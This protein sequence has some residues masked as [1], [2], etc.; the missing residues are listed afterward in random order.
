MA[1]NNEQ[2]KA[3]HDT[4]KVNETKKKTLRTNREALR[5]RI[6]KYFKD[7]HSDYI[8]PKFCWQGSFA[9]NTI[10]NPIKDEGGLGVYDLDDGIYFISDTEDD[11]KELQWY[12]DEV[13]KA[14]EGHTDKGQKDNAPCVTVLYADRHHVDLPI[15]F[16]I[17]GETPQLAHQESFWLE[18][19]PKGLREW[20]NEECNDKSNLKA[21]VRYLK[22]WRD[23][24]DSESDNDDPKMPTG[25]ILT[26]L[27]EEYYVE[28]NADKRED[29]QLKDILIKMYDA[30]SADDGFHCWRPVTPFDDLFDDYKE[31]RKKHFLKELK[32][33]KE[34][35]ERAINL[36]NQKE[37]C[38]KWQKHFG[39]RFC[40]STVKD[41]EEDAQE[42]SFSG[43][44]NNDSKYA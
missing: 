29:I 13:F 17:K 43:T 8:Q 22:A 32:S 30:L 5:K 15:Y 11:R 18:S 42:K 31:K 24:V 40:C 27:A 16:K 38:L 14:V 9:M 25:C 44:I 6:R 4:I 36:K 19:D 39:D 41:E 21:V 1:N 23:Y 34:D 35:A 28:W 37:G 33:F 2:F 20:F 10:L 7:N 12:H 26:M 3:F